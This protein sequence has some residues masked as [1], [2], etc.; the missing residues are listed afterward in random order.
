MPRIASV[1]LISLLL[2][3]AGLSP[4][5][6][7]GD[8]PE[9]VRDLLEQAERQ[10]ESRPEEAIASYREAIRL[11]AS[12]VQSYLALGALLNGQGRTADALQVFEEGLTADADERQLLFNASVLALRLQQYERALGHVQRALKKAKQDADLLSLEAAVLQGLGRHEDALKSLLSAAKK[13]AGDAQILFRLGNLYAELERNDEAIGSYKKAVKKQPDLLRAHFN[14]GAVLYKTQRFDEALEAYRV[15]LEPSE[16][17]FAAGQGVDPANALAYSNLGAIHLA[18]RR[19][20]EAADAYGKALQLDAESP[21]VFYNL[22]FV[23]YQMG[24]EDAAIESYEKALAQQT[25]LPLASLHVGLM[26][27][28]KGQDRLAVPRLQEA[29]PK[30]SGK[31]LEDALWALA[32]SQRA[33]DLPRDAEASL[34][35]L[36]ELD[37]EHLPAQLDLARLLRADGRVAQARS[38]LRQAEGNHGDDLTVLLELA[39]LARLEADRSAERHYYEKVLEAGQAHA[40][41]LWPARLRLVLMLL[42]E[43]EVSTS[44]NHLRQLNALVASGAAEP[45]MDAAQKTLV[46]TLDGIVQLASGDVDGATALLRSAAA[47]GNR[48]AERAMVLMRASRGE[49]GAASE[50][51]QRLATTDDPMA[52]ANLAQLLWLSG[53]GEAARPHLQTALASLPSWPSLHAALGHLDLAAGRYSDAEPHLQRAR[54]LCVDHGGKPP[55]PPAGEGRFALLVGGDGSQLCAW[56]DGSLAAAQVRQGLQ[57]LDRSLLGAS[58]SRDLTRRMD[59][60]LEHPLTPEDRAIALFLR[61]TAR[62]HQ[63]RHATARQ[64]L[65]TALSAE[66]P[67][68]LRLATRNNLAMAWL[69]DGDAA[70]AAE[71]L[72]QIDGLRGPPEVRLNLAILYEQHLGQPETALTYYDAYLSSPTVP[73]RQE[74]EAWVQRLRKVYHP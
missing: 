40:R 41:R 32:R 18:E 9:V 5:E 28:R 54:Q 63:G 72:R 37:G 53:Q 58:G 59:M 21:G 74:V 25:E 47:G 22:G 51:F 16:R 23:Q 64:D 35:R 46:Q 48:S 49:L 24:Q 34:R 6:A 60:A 2:G 12:V 4:V 33:L 27:Q 71:V 26:R 67:E 66:L 43:G 39:G 31:D 7:Q 70:Q 8:V 52:A 13:R 20:V 15:A 57:D 56:V 19:W 10:Q 11:D 44:A 55:A 29:V 38:L 14:L 61:G 73:R 3:F 17:A 42:E 1:L 68:E 30:V 69:G 45:P 65:Q 62:L 50:D 36:L